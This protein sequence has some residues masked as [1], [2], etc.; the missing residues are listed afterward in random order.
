MLFLSQSTGPN[1]TIGWSINCVNCYLFLFHCLSFTR[2]P[3]SCVNISEAGCSSI[4]IIDRNGWNAFTPTA[5]H[6]IIGNQGWCGVLI[7]HT[8][9]PSCD[10]LETCKARV[11]FVQRCHMRYSESGE[12]LP[13]WGKL[14]L[15]NRLPEDF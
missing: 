7:H 1:Q 3:F 13:D 4:E 9:G 15:F 10:S 5:P 6:A 2:L 11:K 12:L 14:R 8:L